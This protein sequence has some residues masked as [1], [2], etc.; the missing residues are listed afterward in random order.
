MPMIGARFYTQLDAAQLHS[1]VL[2]NEVAKE[3]EN[4]RLFKLVVKLATINERP[5]LNMEPTWA[6][7]GDRYMLKLFRDYVFHQV[8]AEGKPWL[9]MAHVVSCLNKLD[10]GSQDKVGRCDSFWE[11]EDVHMLL[12]FWSCITGHSINMKVQILPSRTRQRFRFRVKPLYRL[13]R[14]QLS[15]NICFADLSNV[16]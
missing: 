4:G 10:A 1:D 11:R 16:A 12:Q 8:T 2:E 7:T 13:C 5:E 6:E 3:L 14:H 15:S 9:D